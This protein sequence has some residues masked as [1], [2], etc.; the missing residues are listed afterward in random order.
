MELVDD[1]ELDKLD[2][3]EKNLDNLVIEYENKIRKALDKHT[4][5]IEHIIVIRHNFPW[6]TDE[7]H[8]EKRIVRR[9]EKSGKSIN[10]TTS[11]KHYNTNMTS[12]GS[13]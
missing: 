13:C 2:F 12:I 9:Q 11:G 1:M 5:Q 7:V 3:S 10:R 4:P 6:F 8:Q